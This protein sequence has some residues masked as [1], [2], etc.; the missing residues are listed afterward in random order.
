MKI[1]SNCDISSVLF[2][3]QARKNINYV[4]IQ[5]LI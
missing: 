5:N 1:N 3:L 4:I 2:T